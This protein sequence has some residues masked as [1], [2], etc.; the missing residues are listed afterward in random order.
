MRP[1]IW[2][3]GTKTVSGYWAFN[4]S[5]NRFVIQIDHA[6]HKRVFHVYGDSPEWGNWKMRAQKPAL[7]PLYNIEDR[8]HPI[9]QRKPTMTSQFPETAEQRKAGMAAFRALGEAE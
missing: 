7:K 3:N 1:A 4:W 9:Y 8:E 6:K 2:V 5:A